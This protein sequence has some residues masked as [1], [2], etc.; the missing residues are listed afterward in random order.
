MV[1]PSQHAIEQLDL[2]TIV[3][4]LD[5]PPGLVV[6]SQHAPHHD[7]VSPSSKSL[8]H[9]PRTCAATIT[10]DMTTQTMGSI[11]TLQHSRELGV[12][13]TSLLPGGAHR[14]WA[15]TN[16]DNVSPRQQQL[17]HHLTGHHIARQDGV[18]GVGSPHLPHIHHKVLA[19]PIGNIQADE[20]HTGDGSQDGLEPLKVP[21]SSPRAGSYIL[22]SFRSLGCKLLP[23]VHRVELVHAGEAAVLC[24]GLGHL[25][26]THGVHVGGHDGHTI[27]GLLGVPKYNLSVE[28]NISPALECTSLWP[29][30]H[31]LKVQFYIIHYIRHLAAAEAARSVARKS[32]NLEYWVETQNSQNDLTAPSLSKK[33]LHCTCLQ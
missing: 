26:R 22:H 14:P 28:V 4:N 2:N 12:A 20:G 23:L 31:V 10:D 6:P 8:G 11:C 9:I 19:V 32:D 33:A 27:V 15:N 18:V 29:E 5:L 3:L 25:E 7:K 1:M 30:Q 17:L 24:Q 21:S 13:N 16:L